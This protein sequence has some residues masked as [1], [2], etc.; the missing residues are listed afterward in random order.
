MAGELE[1]RRG[2]SGQRVEREA[3]HLAQRIFG[4]T[5]ETLLPV[6]SK[7]NL[8]EPDPCDHA[9]DEARL[10]GHRQQSVE[11]TP[12]HQPEVAGVDGDFDF[13]RA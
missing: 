10:L 7:W 6:V 11:R 13:G 5:G 3:H 8:P 12:A 4:L 9:A 1:R 2:E